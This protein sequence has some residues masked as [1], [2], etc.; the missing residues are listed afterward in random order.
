VIVVAFR[1]R[2][3]LHGRAISWGRGHGI[4]A[5]IDDDGRLLV[6]CDDGTRDALDAGEVHLA[7]VR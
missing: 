7:P 2:D 3:A 1:E 5:G 6:D 4:A